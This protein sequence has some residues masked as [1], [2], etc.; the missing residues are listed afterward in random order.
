MNC[1][2][3]KTS[4]EDSKSREH[5]IPESLG[6]EEHILPP[7]IVC[8]SC[9]NYFAVKIEQPLLSFPYFQSLRSRLRIPSKR[10]IIP[11]TQG[12]LRPILP[13]QIKINIR[14]EIDGSLSIYPSQEKDESKFIQMILSNKSNSMIIPILDYDSILEKEESMRLLSRFVAKVGI[15]VLAQ[16]LIEIPNG[17]TKEIVENASLDRVRFYARFDKGPTWKLSVARQYS[18]DK[19]HNDLL[20]NSS[21]QILHEYDIYAEE[22][23]NYFIR[24]TIAG[25]EYVLNLADPEC[26]YN[27][28]AIK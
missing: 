19:I 17:I 6:N 23:K 15:E 8:D 12:I 25:V 11:P 4:T 5:I 9:N 14:P 1:V 24:L 2:F 16:K 13:E 26:G 10:N 21:Y 20:E 7:G 3:C 18:E 27:G 22:N 28:H